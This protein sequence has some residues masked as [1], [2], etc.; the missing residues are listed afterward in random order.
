VSFTE[1]LPLDNKRDRYLSLEEEDSLL[2]HSSPSYLGQVI[3]FAIHTGCRRG[4]I[5]SVDW[6]ANIDILGAHINA[7]YVLR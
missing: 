7:L 4:E 5:L 6:R 1:L 3:I 2:S